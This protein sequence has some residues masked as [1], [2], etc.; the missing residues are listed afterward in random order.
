MVAVPRR[1]ILGKRYAR[2]LENNTIRTHSEQRYHVE[3]ATAEV[4]PL[5]AARATLV[6]HRTRRS[7]LCAIARLGRGDPELLR[8]RRRRARR[9]IE[10]EASDRVYAA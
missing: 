6:A 9:R 8:P 7:R 3:H 10:S 4:N 2:R 5:A 1:N